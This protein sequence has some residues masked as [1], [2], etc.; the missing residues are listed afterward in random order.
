MP[1]LRRDTTP[2]YKNH[3]DNGCKFVRETFNIDKCTLCPLKDYC[4]EDEGRSVAKYLRE[5]RNKNIM[6]LHDLGVT[7]IAIANN[8]ELSSDYVRKLIKKQEMSGKVVIL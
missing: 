8:C 3:P 6:K 4:V 7:T 1:K 5:E 2:T